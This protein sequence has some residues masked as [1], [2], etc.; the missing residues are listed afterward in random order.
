MGDEKNAELPVL[1]P[2]MQH[3]EEPIRLLH[4]KDGGRFIE[5]QD[6]MPKKKLFENLDLLL[7]TRRQ[8]TD[9]RRK[10]DGERHAGTEIL[11]V[12]GFVPPIDNR[13]SG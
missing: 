5:D 9:L 1:R 12:P 10:V 11:Q 8:G 13:G 7:F 3:A 2:L 4:R 6:V